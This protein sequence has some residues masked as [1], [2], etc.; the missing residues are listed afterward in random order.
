MR[1]TEPV[2]RGRPRSAEADEAILAAALGLVGEVGVGGLSMDDVASRAGVS[3]ATIYRRWESKEALVLD[4]LNSGISH[5]PDID[6]GTLDGDLH[7]YV[8]ELARRYRAGSKTR[9]LIPHLISAAAANPAL[10]PA[11]DE[12]GEVRSRPL[13]TLFERAV[14]RGELP[15]DVDIRLAADMLLGAMNHR[16]SFFGQVYDDTDTD[17]L[18]EYVLRAVGARV[19]GR[20]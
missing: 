7:A 19:A 3:K 13:I 18:A 9:D 4:A 15:A 2:R 12:F 5:F 1:A 6:T 16:R 8:A 20:V 10:Q 17:R 14:D 11:L